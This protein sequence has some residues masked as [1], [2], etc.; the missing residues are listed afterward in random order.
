MHFF[1]SQS[2]R[3]Q[4]V[5]AACLMAVPIVAA[6]AWDVSRTRLE[7]T[8]DVSDHAASVAMSAATAVD[9]FFASLDAMA[10]VLVRHPAIAAL[11]TSDSNRLLASFVAEQP[12][13]LNA[14]L[15][16]RA[17]IVRAAAS[18]LEDGQP[19]QTPVPAHVLDVLATGRPVTSELTTGQLTGRP[20]VAQAY[21]VRA[22]DGS[23]AGVVSFGLNVTELQSVFGSIPL[24]DGSI[25]TLVDRESRILV[26]SLEAERY[27]GT[28]FDSRPIEPRDVPPTFTRADT[29]GVSRVHAN[30]IVNRGPWLL[31]VAI[32]E[33][34]VLAEV[35]PA[36]RR[37]LAVGLSGLAGVLVLMLWLSRHTSRGLEVLRSGAQRIAGG[38]LSPPPRGLIPNL[39]VGQLHDAFVTMAANLRETRSALDRQV[40]EERKMREELQSLQRQLVRQER[41]AA[42]GVLV[43]G[44]AHELN[45]PLQSILGTAELLERQPEIGGDARP[46]IALLK[47]QSIRARETIR[48]L[49]R[50]SSPQ[51]GPPAL[52]DLRDIVD[53]VVGLR[54][55]DA[56]EAAIRI[57]VDA[58]CRGTVFA[59]FTEIEQ[60]LLN[61]IINAEQA[62]ASGGRGAGRILVRL[63]DADGR[64]RVQVDDDGSGV[65][66]DCE[67]KLFQPFFTTK[68]VGQ[69][70]GLGLS[71]SYGII[72]SYGGSIGHSGNAWGG[73]TFFFELPACD[74]KAGTSTAERRQPD[75]DRVDR[76]DDAGSRRLEIV[77]ED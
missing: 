15:R 46:E 67:A 10:S 63:S 7:R 74:G 36:W 40:E 64:V 60:V 59:N 20:I 5:A 9:Q 42:V 75:H 45:N 41:L 65:P 37:D 43:A 61:L 70:T 28:P 6:T 13:V 27:I 25:I 24:P 18:G 16:D 34:L 19:R 23:I 73:A 52:V 1:A 77:G 22:K 72:E 50:F 49:A 47:T 53:E 39:E 4:M 12:L 2:L 62:I 32:P 71:V 55:Q 17:G 69:G 38:D 66:A 51:P 30:A 31:S 76:G 56:A 3:R 48:K 11:D 54:H 57:D 58:P 35:A 21:P 33:S 26:R 44:I 68:P 8:A 14:A 29:D